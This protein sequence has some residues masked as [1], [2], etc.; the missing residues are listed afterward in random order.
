MALHKMI[1]RLKDENLIP[2]LDGLFAAEKLFRKNDAE[3]RLIYTG[4]EPQEAFTGV[5]V[6]YGEL[7]D[8]FEA[9]DLSFLKACAEWLWV[10]EKAHADKLRQEPSRRKQ[11]DAP[12][13]IVFH[14]FRF[15]PERI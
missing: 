9:G 10:V 2:Y 15:R 7:D 14:G 12:Y 3:G 13:E 8:V 11:G 6:I 5:G 1:F 4:H